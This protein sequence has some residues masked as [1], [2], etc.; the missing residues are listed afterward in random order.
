MLQNRK[1]GK[2]EQVFTSNQLMNAANRAFDWSRLLTTPTQVNQL[3]IMAA[4]AQ[5][6][7]R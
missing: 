4:H 1:D 6:H 5:A 7:Y 3:H 2:K